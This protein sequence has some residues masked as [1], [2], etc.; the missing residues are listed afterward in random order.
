[1]TQ[2][3]TVRIDVDAQ[4]ALAPTPWTERARIRAGFSGNTSGMAPGYAQGN[5]VVLPKAW[6]DDFAAY[7]RANPTPCPLIGMT[8]P[9]SSLVP[10]L[11]DNIDLRTDLPR[12]RVWRDGELVEELDDV[13]AL[14]Q[15]DWVGFVIGCSLSFEHAL[16][17]AGL[18]VRHVDEQKV[19]PMYRTSIQ[20][21]QVG[22]FRGPMVVSMRPYTPEHA[23]IA[24]AICERLPGAHGAPVHI[25][26]PAAIGIRNVN[27][28]DEGE[29]TAILDGE[30][31]VF[32]GCGVTPQAAVIE[33]RPPICITHAPG[34]MLICDV[35]TD[36]LKL[37]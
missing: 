21:R 7:C 16:Q 18:N 4:A 2:T 10:M 34:H 36:D 15:A 31:P 30:T 22:A 25:G 19:V 11:G 12:Y 32:W 9:G 35:R 5:L 29:P 6:A 13:S 24:Y 17:V 23:A 8:E 1:M 28:P 37:L 33:A 20:T 26:D 14:W 3:T 27:V